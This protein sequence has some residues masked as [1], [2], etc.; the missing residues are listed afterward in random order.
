MVGSSWFGSRRA[1][2]AGTGVLLALVAGSLSAP[3]H[4]APEPEV[5]AVECPTALPRTAVAVGLVG[6]GRTVVTGTGVRRTER[7]RTVS[8]RTPP[9]H[10][11][12]AR[13]LGA[14]LGATGSLVPRAYAM[15][16]DAAA[17]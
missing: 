12:R 8:T 3:A 11:V 16:L 2:A 7:L 17:R 4:A 15:G 6:E 1:T 13:S 5:G 9:T 14:V 10:A